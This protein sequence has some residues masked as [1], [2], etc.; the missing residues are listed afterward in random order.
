MDNQTHLE[1]YTAHNDE[2]YKIEV[3]MTIHTRTGKI[4]SVEIRITTRSTTFKVV[5]HTDDVRVVKIIEKELIAPIDA[6]I[7]EN[8]T[9]G[10]SNTHQIRLRNAIRSVC[11]SRESKIRKLKLEIEIAKLQK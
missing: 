6:K 7:S 9:N 5:D 4:Q 2:R 10:V 11:S 3:I 1:T 8:L